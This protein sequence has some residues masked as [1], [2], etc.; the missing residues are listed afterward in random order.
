MA[1]LT[2][3]DSSSLRFKAK[4]NLKVLLLAMPVASDLLI[5]RRIR[6]QFEEG[7]EKSFAPKQL[8]LETVAHC[9]ASCVMCPY[10]QMR[11]PKGIMKADVHKMIIDSTASWGA[12]IQVISHAGLGEPLIDKHLAEKIAYERKVFPDAT[13]VVY[14][15]ASLLDERR[16]TELIE[17][18]VDRISVSLNGFYKDT[19]ETVMKLPYERT[20]ENLHRFVELRKGL[21]KAPQFHVSLIPTEHHS[22]QEILEFKEFW[23]GKADSVIVPPYITWGDFFPK[24]ARGERQWPCRYIWEVLQIDWDGTVKMCCEDY[25]S[26]FP[27]GNVLEESPKAIFNSKLLNGQ[28]RNQIAG[29]FDT[30]SICQDCH[31][32]HG[33][34]RDFWINGNVITDVHT[35]A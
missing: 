29:K 30:P 14:T 35:P 31:E 22:E 26:E 34:A 33:V 10:P 25:D 13:L 8:A 32:T 15:N 21:E 12:P 20:Y 24:L 18:G 3:P 16:A 6:R 17:A 2:A 5:E 4:H 28:R 19:Y 1:I 9:N 11:R 23:G 7:L 27:L